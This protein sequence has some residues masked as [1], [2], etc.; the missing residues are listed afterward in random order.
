[1][2]QND[3]PTLESCFAG[4]LALLETALVGEDALEVLRG[5]DQPWMEEQLEQ[6]RLWTSLHYELSTLAATPVACPQDRRLTVLCD[7]LARLIDGDP[8]IDPLLWRLALPPEV[9]DEDA[10]IALLRH[11][12]DLACAWLKLCDPA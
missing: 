12:T 6:D 5:L 9:P 2:F 3:F 4:A 8:E 1:M 11:A 10:F 7:R